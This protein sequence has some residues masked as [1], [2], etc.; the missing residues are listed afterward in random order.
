[1]GK[2]K[3]VTINAWK[4][5]CEQDLMT[6]IHTCNTNTSPWLA[7]LGG[8]TSSLLLSP[9]AGPPS[10]RGHAPLPDPADCDPPD[11]SSEEQIQTS[12]ITHKK[13]EM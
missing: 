11:K 3:E 6:I 9:A 13:T 12:T 10:P 2:Y 8:A 4:G 1:M 5:L 7:P